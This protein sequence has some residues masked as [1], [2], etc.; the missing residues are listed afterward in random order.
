MAAAKALAAGKVSAMPIAQ[1]VM[2]STRDSPKIIPAMWPAPKPRVLKTAYSPMR[3]LAVMAMVLAT[4]A[5]IMIITT[6]ETSFMTMTMA[7]VMEMKPRAKAFSDSVSVSAREFLKMPS[8]ASV[9]SEE[10]A[11]LVIPI[12]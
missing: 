7:S 4:T 11:G 8:M 1:P 12:M 5:M 2:V 6:N 9:T 10:S 3:S